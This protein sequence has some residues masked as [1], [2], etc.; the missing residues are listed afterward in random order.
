MKKRL[1]S[2]TEAFNRHHLLTM[3]GLIFA[4]IFVRYCYYG[5]SYYHQLDDYIQ[6]HN[7]A[8]RG[9]SLQELAAQLGLLAA[10]PLA[11]LADIIVWSRMFSVMLVAVAA[12]S[13]LLAGSACLF[14]DVFRRRF[15]TG[16]L[17]CV[18]LTLLPLGFEGTYWVSASSRVVVGMFFVSLAL[19]LFERW[20]RSGR[21]RDAILCAVAQLAAYGFYE[22]AM[23]ASFAALVLFAL[24][25]FGNR[26]GWLALCG[27]ANLGIFFAVTRFFSRFSGG[28]LYAQR[29]QLVDITSRS[30]YS[31]KIPELLRQIWSV[32]VGGGFF[33]LAKGFKRGAKSLVT[34]PN[35]V[36]LLVVLLLCA[37]LWLVTRRR[38]ADAVLTAS[39]AKKAPFEFWSAL[40]IGV[41]LTL[42][43]LAPFFLIAE[44]WF[45]MRGAVM[46]L[47]GVALVVDTLIRRL[48]LRA[49]TY[50][51]LGAVLALVCS[52]ASVSELRDYRDT[53]AHDMAFVA[54]LADAV[55]G[56][57]ADTRIA[58]L[59]VEPSYLDDQNYFYHEH[60]HGITES[61]WA[62]QGGLEY[63]IGAENAPR[64]TPLPRR[65]MYW[66]WNCEVSRLESFDML[67]LYRDGAL[68]EVVPS[69]E[70][71]VTQ[72]FT[73]SGEYVGYV[74]EEDEHGYLELGGS[75]FV[76]S[77]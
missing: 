43:P 1:D 68:V 48:P 15:G 16:S 47:A 17:F 2:L 14:Y 35:F 41:L 59:N 4:L 66:P 64:V 19:W 10:R 49:R 26:R 18:V 52:V 12:I 40:V 36:W 58:I 77:D 3:L 75:A 54:L 67:L 25:S 24:L 70:G 65:P 55:E 11:G 39:D 23:V 8:R 34:G 72:L 13:L 60:I 71:E 53:T 28:E 44:T 21:V 20:L 45:S 31:T 74:W 69:V 38:A 7:Y 76:G 50:A 33:T 61:S 6:Y 51:A 30:F 46:S 22:Q 27:V 56:I 37:V 42:T 32:F 73:R 63:R 29:T 9:L 62:L 5:F 57:D